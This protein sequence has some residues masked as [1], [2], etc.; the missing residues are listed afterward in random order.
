MFYVYHTGEEVTDD[1]ERVI[2]IG[3]KELA[4]LVFDVGLTSW[5]INKV[6]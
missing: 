4:N 6:S 2:V 1:K 5:L 3:P